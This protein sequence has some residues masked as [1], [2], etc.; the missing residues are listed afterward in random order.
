MEKEDIRALELLEAVV[1]DPNARQVDLARRVGVAVGTVNWLLKRMVAKGQIKVKRIGR[2]QWRYLLTPQGVREKTKLTQQ[3]IQASFRVY[4]ETREEARQLLGELKHSGHT[5][6][7]LEADQKND[8]LDI[9]RLTCAEL[10][11][12]VVGDEDSPAP[13]LQAENRRIVLK[14]PA[15]RAPIP[16]A[17]RVDKG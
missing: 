1:E 11:I 13:I 16:P 15:C 14:N 2:W 5:K 10:G 7:H 12:T 17:D 4:R 6:V 9:Y 3:Y 8:L